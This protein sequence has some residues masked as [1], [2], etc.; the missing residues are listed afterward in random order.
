M[1]ASGI[2]K[3]LLAE[4]DDARLQ[5]A[6]AG[7]TLTAFTP[8]SITHLDAL[9]ADLAQVRARGYAVD[10]EERNIGMRCIAAPVFDIHQEAV[11]GISVSGPTSRVGLEDIER[12]SVAVRAAAADLSATL[13]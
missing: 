13:G 12:L 6:L 8:H 11:A 2:G 5:R 1:H 4:M 9:R 7:K 3:A 10:A